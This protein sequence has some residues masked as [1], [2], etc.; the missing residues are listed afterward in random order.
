M[1]S[2][3][4][5]ARSTFRFNAWLRRSLLSNVCMLKT[6]YM[7]S[8]DLFL[9]RWSLALVF[10]ECRSEFFNETIRRDRCTRRSKS[11]AW[12]KSPLK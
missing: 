7:F 8:A 6:F 9:F 1:V 12:L 3:L 10:I 4:R 5:L 2:W 11:R